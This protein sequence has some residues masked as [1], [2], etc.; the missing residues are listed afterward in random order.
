[1]PYNNVTLITNISS[2]FENIIVK[3]PHTE[4]IFLLYYSSSSTPVSVCRTRKSINFDEIYIQAPIHF[5]KTV[6]IHFRYINYEKRFFFPPLRIILP[7]L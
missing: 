4:W 7:S 3:T 6:T 2:M 5:V 1:M